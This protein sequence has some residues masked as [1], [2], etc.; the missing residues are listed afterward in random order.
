MTHGS[1]GAR[2]SVY[3]EAGF[4]LGLGIPVIYTCR[5]D[6][7]DILHFDT[8]QYLHIGWKDDE[9]ETLRR[10]LEHRIRALIGAGPQSST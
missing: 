5:A 10:N 8:R 7:F 2:G 1:D 6:M 4:A 3:L 9:V